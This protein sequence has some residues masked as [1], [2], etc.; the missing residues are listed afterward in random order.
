[1]DDFNWK[2]I[3]ILAGAVG[4]LAY[5][6]IVLVSAP[7]VE[8]A[9]EVA[10]TAETGE[11]AA[12]L[13]V[14]DQETLAPDSAS[15]ESQPEAEPAFEPF[16]NLLDDEIWEDPPPEEPAHE[17]PATPP[18]PTEDEYHFR[19]VRWG[20]SPDE[21]RAAED[22][23]PA[24]AG[25]RA[26]TY[27]TTTVE[28]PCRLTYIFQWDAL[29][30]IHLAF[31]DPEGRD[32]PPLSLAQ[33]Q[34]RFL[35][36]REQLRQRY[37][38]PRER[39]ITVP[40]DV[41]ALQRRLDKQDE[42]ARQYDH[43]IAIAEERLQRRRETLHTRYERWQR[44]DE[45]IA[46]DLAPYE[47]DLRDLKT[48]KK[49]ALE[50]AAHASR[51][52]QENKAADQREPLVAIMFARWSNARDLQDIELRLDMRAQVPRLDIRYRAALPPVASEDF[53]EL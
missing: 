12:L 34:R 43:E 30:R 23:S 47:R 14:N 2:R 29:V 20:M 41:T 50:T 6:G 53:D 18:L 46:R 8:H 11:I 28:L 21:V 19:R 4:L 22:A 44:R 36:L 15:P 38:P 35:F 42:L 25:S 17:D 45:L 32:I 1:M 3:L 7:V 24:H 16:W 52:I 48:W 26:L 10:R 37:G 27:L 31:S 33:A 5:V 51:R 13:P 40:R 49:E 39:T 9:D